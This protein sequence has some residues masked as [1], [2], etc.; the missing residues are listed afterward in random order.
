[1]RHLS[2]WVGV[3]AVFLGGVGLWS[4]AAAQKGVRRQV[5]QYLGGITQAPWFNQS[6]IRKQL[7]F[8]DQ[9]FQQFNK[10]YQNSWTQFDKSV[11]GLNDLDAQQRAAQM[12]KLSQTFNDSFTKATQDILKPEQQQR[13][14]QLYLQYLGHRAFADPRVQDKLSLTD[15]QREAFRNY[16]AAYDQTLSKLYQNFPDSRDEATRRFTE[17]RRDS[18]ERIGST[19]TPQQMQIWREMIGQPYMFQ[20]SWANPSPDGKR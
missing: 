7:G 9:Q 19:L 13:Y 11:Q 17:L 8:T 5:Q 12:S 4:Q 2:A 3:T 15:K 6:G 10:A 16:A 14:N 1:M 20:P 18:T